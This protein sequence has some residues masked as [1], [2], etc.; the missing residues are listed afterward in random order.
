VPAEPAPDTVCLASGG[1]FLTKLGVAPCTWCFRLAS[2]A[3]QF[4]R[5]WAFGAGAQGG[6][7]QV[8]VGNGASRNHCS[9]TLDDSSWHPPSAHGVSVG[10]AGS[11]LCQRTWRHG[12]RTR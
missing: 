1:A 6:D 10:I 9:P 5:I 4:A 11:E 2:A 8:D 3:H 12:A 7:E